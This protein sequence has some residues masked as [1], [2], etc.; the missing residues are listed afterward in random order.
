M[1]RRFLVRLDLDDNALDEARD[2]DDIADAAVRSARFNVSSYGS[3]GNANQPVPEGHGRYKCLLITV[4]V[5]VRD[6]MNLTERKPSNV[7]DS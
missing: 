7:F 5:G 4:R 6:N 2:C 1:Q 3:H